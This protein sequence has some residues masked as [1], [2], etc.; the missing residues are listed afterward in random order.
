MIY[1]KFTVPINKIIY[2]FAYETNNTEKGMYYKKEP[3]LGI[4]VQSQHGNLKYFYEINKKHEII[5]SKKVNSWSRHYADTY[6]E[7]LEGYNKL[8]ENHIKFLNE[9]IKNHQ[10]DLIK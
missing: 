8:I 4:V 3:I 1:D 7:A 6:S 10:K 2:G 9:L 5:K